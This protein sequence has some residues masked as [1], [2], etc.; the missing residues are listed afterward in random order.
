MW[1]RPV[2]VAA[3]CNTAPFVS[4]M[5]GQYVPAVNKP[6][7]NGVLGTTD[8]R[9]GTKNFKGLEENDAIVQWL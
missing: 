4:H 3:K 2:H 8:M 7:P 1:P 9:T 6:S 5:P